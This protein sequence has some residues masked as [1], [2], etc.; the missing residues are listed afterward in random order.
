MKK[1]IKVFLFAFISSMCLMITCYASDVSDNYL[2][3]NFG[4]DSLNLMPNEKSYIYGE[5]VDNFNCISLKTPFKYDMFQ[6]NW[7][8]IQYLFKNGKL[9]VLYA[10]KNKIRDKYATFTG[11]ITKEHFVIVFKRDAFNH[12]NIPT[13]LDGIVDLLNRRNYR[14]GIKLGSAEA[15]KLMNHNFSNFLGVYSLSEMITML[16][17]GLIDAFVIELKTIDE[18]EKKFDDGFQK[19][20]IF[21]IPKGFYIHNDFLKKYPKFLTNF[22][23]G[24]KQCNLL[25]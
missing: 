3:L 2:N 14:V 21:T 12:K 7:S 25:K 24:L 1:V 10:S 18:Y 19:R 15:L 11:T 5:V 22:S 23:R 16:N 4:F 8:R 13:D 20:Y 17:D 9:D 6:G